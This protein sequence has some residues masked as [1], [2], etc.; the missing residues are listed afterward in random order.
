MWES[1]LRALENVGAEVESDRGGEAFFA[2]HELRAL[3]GGLAGTLTAARRAI[4][5]PIRIAAAPTR[6][7]A[8]LAAS[9]FGPRESRHRVREQGPGA[10][11]PAVSA[12]P[13]AA[14][15]GASRPAVVISPAELHQFLTPIP[16]TTLAP[17][18]DLQSGAALRLTRTLERLGISCLG[19]LAQLPTHAVADRL[20]PIGLRAQRLCLGRDEPLRP[21]ARHEDLSAGLELPD[22]ASGPQLQRALEILIGR[23]LADPRRRDRTLRS[24]SVSARLASGGSWRGGRVTLRTPSASPKLILITTAPRLEALPE[25]AISLHLTAL[26]MGPRE[27]DQLELS[28]R[29]EEVRHQR[30]GEAV[31]QT[32]AAAGPESLL[33]VIEIDPD[34]RIP[35]RR[36][37]LTPFPDS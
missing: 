10:P 16:I 25:P 13:G 18:L 23:V 29:P 32:R 30:L 35:E 19:E 21:R 2:A 6:F 33:R 31:R 15:P 11:R 26:E 36:E 20:G 22:S 14:V 27:G 24:L 17:R 28:R 12:T 1:T 4:S 8:F 5:V 7:A 34:S 3:H 9:G 37:M